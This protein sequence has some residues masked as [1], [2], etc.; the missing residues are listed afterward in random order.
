MPKPLRYL[1]IAWSVG[2]GILC[3]LLIALW[4][5]SYSW[6]DFLSWRIVGRIYV[7]GISHEGR[8]KISAQYFRDSVR[9]LESELPPSFL[10][11]RADNFSN[12]ELNW[13]LIARSTPT[14]TTGFGGP[15]WF[16]TLV[17]TFCAIAPWLP[18]RT[19]AGQPWLRW[20]FSLRTLLIAMTL[21]A[22][23]LGAIVF[24]MQ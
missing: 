5:R 19:L 11:S 23:V 15:Y 12:I 24:S 7:N 10:Y 6:E 8:L 14:P 17:A 16:I 3:L 2:C 18:P 4:V 13:T 1:R 22:V 21:A 20:S 9:T